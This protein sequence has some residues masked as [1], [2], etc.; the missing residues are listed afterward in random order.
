MSAR[1]LM[2]ALG[3]G[4]YGVRVARPGYDVRYEPVGSRNI[5]FDSRLEELGTVI[6]S[7]IWAWGG[8]PIFF[9]AMPYVPVA[10]IHQVIGN[11][12]VRD[13]ISSFDLNNAHHKYYPVVAV[14]TQNYL[15][16]VQYSIPWYDTAAGFSY[17]GSV[18]AYTIYGMG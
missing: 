6:A 11:D 4:G 18:W 2:G 8:G 7:G 3:D 12:L 10:S 15:Q 14:I 9:P 16:I 5:S 17:G 1:G 13:G